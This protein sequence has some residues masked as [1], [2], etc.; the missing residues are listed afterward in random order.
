M[1]TT[2]SIGN[3]SL[4]GA[5]GATA[6]VAGSLVDY[7]TAGTFNDRLQGASDLLQAK[8]IDSIITPGGGCDWLYYGRPYQV[9]AIVPDDYSL[10]RFENDVALNGLNVSEPLADCSALI[11]GTGPLTI[12]N[13]VVLGNIPATAKQF[14]KQKLNDGV[15]LK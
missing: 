13:L 2:R 11:H 1:P 15:R 4:Y 3:A 5:L 10:E 8:Q 14:I 9:R 12:E 6:G 7:A